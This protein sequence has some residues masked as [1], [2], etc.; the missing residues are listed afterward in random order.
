MHRR[1][2]L[3]IA[4]ALIL[5]IL[6]FLS[7]NATAF[8]NENSQGAASNAS[9]ERGYAVSDARF[10]RLRRGIN[11]SHWF[12]QSIGKDYSKTHL[13][14]HTTAQDIALIKEMKFDH[15]RFTIE[16][17]PFFNEGAPGT[18]NAEYLR[19][20]DSAV[21][22]MLAH[23]LAVIVDIHPSD[24]F[25]VKLNTDNNHV[26]AFARFWQALA[27]NLSSRDPERLFLEVLNE[28]MV[29]DGYRWAGIQSKI[30]SAIRAGAPHHTIIASGHRWS[31]L[32]ELLFMEPLA[33]PNVVYNFHFY[34]P[35]QFTHQGATWAGPFLATFKDVPYPSSPEAVTKIMGAIP[36]ELARFNLLHYGEDRW[37][38]SRIEDEIGMAAAW[39]R[40]YHVRLT[41]NEFGVYRKFAPPAAR[42][43]WLRDVRVA[44]EKNGIGWTMWDYAGGFAV[45]SKESGRAV[46]DEQ[47]LRAL[48]LR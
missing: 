1:N 4:A 7:T 11:L 43:A 5:A 25:K 36:D 28:P 32:Y 39:A 17:A 41:C 48:G 27:R 46:A 24:E 9:A 47:T 44:L 14:T 13:E 26:E 19:S 2:A 8:T 20:L 15:V 12:A 37:S 16:P 38:A 29:E 18:L 3:S 21:D 45:V 30:I 10:A 23:D 33:D 35:M 42:A 6:P 40:K 34:E 22:M 31:S